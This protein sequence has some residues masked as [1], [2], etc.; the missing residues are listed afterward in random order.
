MNEFRVSVSSLSTHTWPTRMIQYWIVRFV[1]WSFNRS[2]QPSR[3][4]HIRCSLV[5]VSV[6]VRVLSVSEFCSWS[7]G[8]SVTSRGVLFVNYPCPLVFVI[9]WWFVSEFSRFS[10]IHHP[11]IPRPRIQLRTEFFARI[12][13]FVSLPLARSVCTFLWRFISLFVLAFCNALFFVLVL[14]QTGFRI[15]YLRIFRYMLS[16]PPLFVRCESLV[17]SIFF[18]GSWWFSLS[19]VVFSCLCFGVA[20]KIFVL[21]FKMSV[22]GVLSKFLL[23]FPPH[24]VFGLFA[25]IFPFHRVRSPSISLPWGVIFCPQKVVTKISVWNWLFLLSVL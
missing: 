12:L 17:V 18:A 19:L 22:F 7:A 25:S 16:L 8:V 21:A 6:R 23:K 24:N 2:S 4:A 3:G 1:V 5:R 11:P 10:L 14:T 15:E 9:C 20:L 13:L